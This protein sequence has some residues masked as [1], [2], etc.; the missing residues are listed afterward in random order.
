MTP[1]E[2][3]AG[4]TSYAP[5]GWRGSATQCASGHSLRGGGGAVASAGLHL[6]EAALEEGALHVVVHERERLLVRDLRLGE[7][8]EPPEQ[9]RPGGGQVAVPGQ[10]PLGAERV[11]FGEPCRRP[12]CEPDGHGPIERH[13][14]RWPHLAE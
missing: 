2:L 14:R 7:P 6:G 11:Q 12:A 1:D 13:H 8:A 10:L 4:T 9:V 5:S 3:T